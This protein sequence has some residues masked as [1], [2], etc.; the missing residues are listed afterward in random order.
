M[1]DT[2]KISEEEAKQMVGT[3][4]VHQQRE[5]SGEHRIMHKIAAPYSLPPVHSGQRITR[6]LTE[7][8]AR[9]L[10]ASCEFV[11]T[12]RGGFTTFLTLTFDKFA[13]YRMEKKYTSG[14]CTEIKKV[15]GK[16]VPIVTWLEDGLQLPCTTVQ[17]ETSRFF[18]GLQKMY[19]RGWVYDDDLIKEKIHG[20]GY[21]PYSEI[22]GP[23]VQPMKIRGFDQ[24]R[25]FIKDKPEKLDYL[26]VAEN[27]DSSIDLKSGEVVTNPHVHVLMRWNVPYSLFKAW[28]KRVE[29][30]WGLGFAHLEKLR[31]KKK[32][33][34]AGYLMKAL[35]YVA[36]ATGASDQGQIRGNRYGISESARAPEWQTLYAFAWAKLGQLI[37]RARMK[38]N[39]IRKPLEQK[40][41]DL[42]QQLETATT[43]KQ[44]NSIQRALDAARE[45]VEQAKG[46]IYYGRNRVV[47][48]GDEGKSLFYRWAMDKGFEWFDKPLS[49]FVF[50][51]EARLKKEKKRMQKY[52][53]WS[54]Q[55]GFIASCDRWFMKYERDEYFSC[56]FN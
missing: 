50:G 30:L 44:K 20:T 48:Q 54:N 13:R 43:K 10:S 4:A 26:W 29:N 51:L 9:K 8:G 41:D 7:H 42:K 16:W 14:K 31:S 55:S 27:P 46:R 45:K 11:S 12:V 35:Q 53:D 37:E 6:F 38:Q 40:R 56:N 28:A 19:V 49:L 2:I 3:Y 33:S 21:R 22:M 32:E 17:E 36:K 24:C 15:R 18:D 23:Y 25:K 5:W 39:R 1:S 52:L 34:A 47:M